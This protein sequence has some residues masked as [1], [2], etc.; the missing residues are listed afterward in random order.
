ML[1]YM[2]TLHV[3]YVPGLGDAHLAGQQAAVAVWR[4]WGVR[5]E[6][7]AMHW[8]VDEPWADK[9]SRLVAR[10]DALTEAGQPVALVGSSAGASAVIAAFAARKAQVA[11]CVV[12]AGKILRPDAIA[13]HYRQENPALVD[14]VR[15]SEAALKTLSAADRIR[16]MSR[17]A[18][19][20]TV[21][22][23]RD[24]VVEGADNR[25]VPV[26]GH[27]LV[28][29]FMLTLGAPGFVGF[30]QRCRTSA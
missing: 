16:I 10:I 6:V 9:L 15:G 17:Y 5:G 21:V 14:A 30:L 4:L 19:K 23:Q 1:I 24:S 12:I 28:I 13:E 27:T 8:A 20:D 26:S 25:A 29:G 2:P 7:L 18:Q 3:I 11:G 22:A